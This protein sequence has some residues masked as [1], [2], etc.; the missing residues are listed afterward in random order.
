M[1]GRPF[2]LFGVLCVLCVS[3]SRIFAHDLE[4]TQVTLRFSRDGSFVLDVSNDPVWLH[5]RMQSIP[6]PFADR[7]VLWVDGREIRPTTV[8]YIAP[9][10]A[11][12]GELPDL[13]IYRMR[14]RMPVDAKTLR[15]YYGLVIDPYPMT[16]YRADGRI[17]VEEIAGDA[18]S[19][20]IDLAGQFSARRIGDT[21]ATVALLFVVLVP[22]IVWL[23]RRRR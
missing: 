7:V 22:P 17:A 9:P 19:G 21:A 4:R 20:S 8:E 1:A 6:G 18:W 16:I 2:Y 23:S 10:P 5:D 15:W 3:S 14:G 11:T 12:P 13:G